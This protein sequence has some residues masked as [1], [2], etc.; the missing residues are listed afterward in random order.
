MRTTFTSL[1]LTT[2]ATLAASHPAPEA[3]I[4]PAPTPITHL[5]P[6]QDALSSSSS[7][8]ITTAPSC[9]PSLSSIL[10]PFP[11]PPPLVVSWNSAAILRISSAANRADENVFASALGAANKVQALCTAAASGIAPMPTH[12]PELAA[13]YSKY[14][15]QVQMWR[16]AVEGDAYRVAGECGGFVGLGLELLMATEAPMCVSGIRATVRPWSTQGVDGG[17]VLSAAGGGGGKEVL[18]FSL[19]MGVV[20][21]A[22]V[23]VWL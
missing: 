18:S 8:T 1:L 15:D 21:G 7:A 10:A 2:V 20:V 4:T 17:V 19:V 22:A 16:F 9:L 6:R 23:L 5:Q 13:A 12:A 14:L 11:T 3:L